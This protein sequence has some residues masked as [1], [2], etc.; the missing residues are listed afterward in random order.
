MRSPGGG[1]IWSQNMEEDMDVNTMPDKP[2]NVT[3]AVNV[4]YFS[5]GIGLTRVFLEWSLVCRSGCARR[6]PQAA[7]Q[8]IEAQR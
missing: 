4:L 2:S 3:T 1:R 6:R 5:L 7:L 8:V